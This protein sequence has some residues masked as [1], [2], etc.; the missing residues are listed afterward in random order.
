MRLPKEVYVEGRLL[1]LVK[2]FFFKKKSPSEVYYAINHLFKKL[3]QIHISDL[4]SYLGCSY[5]LREKKQVVS[6]ES[7]CVELRMEFSI[8]QQPCF[9]K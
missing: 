2:V 8:S 3:M 9:K 1:L 6:G 4:E 7:Q 5:M